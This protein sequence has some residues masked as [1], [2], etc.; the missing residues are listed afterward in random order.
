MVP[1]ERTAVVPESGNR[2]AI[3]LQVAV[4]QQL[5]RLRV[6]LMASTSAAAGPSSSADGLSLAAE[7]TPDKQAA[8]GR[9]Q[10]ERGLAVPSFAAASFVVA[11]FVVAVAA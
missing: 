5:E 1:L 6:E 2:A 11:K 10:L 7:D 8:M 4:V 9:P 3:H